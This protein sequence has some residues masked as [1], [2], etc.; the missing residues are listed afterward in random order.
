MHHSLSSTADKSL[1]S[2]VIAMPRRWPLRTRCRAK[3]SNP[4]S[5]Q[6]CGWN[7]CCGFFLARMTTN[8]GLLLFVGSIVV[9]LICFGLLK[10]LENEYE[11]TGYWPNDHFCSDWDIAF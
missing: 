6:S 3:G 7:C 11:N 5:D 2:S 4:W 8:T 9:L 10:L 1:F